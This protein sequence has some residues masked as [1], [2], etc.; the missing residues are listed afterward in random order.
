[1]SAEVKVGELSGVDK[2][3]RNHDSTWGKARRVADNL[4]NNQDTLDNRKPFRLHCL[5]SSN[6]KT[7][8]FQ[9]RTGL[10]AVEVPRDSHQPVIT[11]ENK[12]ALSRE[13]SF[14]A[15][16]SVAGRTHLS[17]GFPNESHHRSIAFPLPL[18]LR[19]LPF[20][21]INFSV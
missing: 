14:G 21:V 20:Q 12:A 2:G 10:S 9:P 15:Q 16:T 18:P 11:N 6:S 1:M 17:P 5:C 13:F 4:R 8:D 3:L 7:R 19:L